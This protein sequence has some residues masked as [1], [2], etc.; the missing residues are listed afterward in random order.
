MTAQSIFHVLTWIAGQGVIG[1]A[2]PP[3]TWV[4]IALPL[5]KNDITSSPW[6]D[7]Y[8]DTAYVGSATGWVYK[9]TGVFRGTP[10]LVTASP[11]P[12]QVVA[13]QAL[14]SPVLDSRLGKLMIGAAN[15]NLYQ[16]DTT[17][18]AVSPLAVGQGGANH[19]F[20][21]APIVDVANGVTFAVN[22]YCGNACYDGNPSGAVL[23]EVNTATLGLVTEVSLGEGSPTGTTIDLYQPALDHNYYNSPTTGLIHLCGTGASDATPYHFAFG[24]TEPGAVPVLKTLPTVH[25]QLPT[26]PAGTTAGCTGW[27]EFFNPNIGTGGTDF[28]FFGLN[29]ACTAAGTAGGCVE[30]LAINGV[31]TTRTTR[32]VA[33]GSTGVVIDNYSTAAQASSIYFGARLGP[34]TAYKMT[35]NGLD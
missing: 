34:G 16:V 13:N 2:V 6:I 26:I 18:G 3:T 14:T 12:I 19:A 33:G 25:Q 29:Q 28:F 7:Y 21:A 32:V 8:F 10:T 17:S 35:Q 30:E 20:Q 4:S 22:A 27:T 11:W 24:F 23:V 5:A 31:T 15:G 9:I 1:G